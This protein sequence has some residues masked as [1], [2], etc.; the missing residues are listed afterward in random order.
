MVEKELEV[1]FQITSIQ[2]LRVRY[3]PLNL[4]KI[5]NGYMM[6]ERSPNNIFIINDSNLKNIR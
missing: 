6:K 5:L 4:T 2:E 3:Q 1:C